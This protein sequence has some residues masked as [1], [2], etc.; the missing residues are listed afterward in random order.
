MIE[1]TDNALQ[2]DLNMIDGRL[3]LRNTG[4]CRGSKRSACPDNLTT[5]PHLSRSYDLSLTFAS[6]NDAA[7]ALA[8]RQATVSL[9]DF[10]DAEFG[11]A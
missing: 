3:C 9:A 2:I 8:R 1:G 7:N 5:I 6:P 10:S 11:P 4:Y